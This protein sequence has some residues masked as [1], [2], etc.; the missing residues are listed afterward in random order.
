MQIYT[1]SGKHEGRILEPGGKNDGFHFR[2]T[3]LSPSGESETGRE[4]VRDMTVH[5]SKILR[6]TAA[7]T[8]NSMCYCP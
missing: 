7:I 1:P 4:R 8:K 3:I 5:G 6:E 2:G